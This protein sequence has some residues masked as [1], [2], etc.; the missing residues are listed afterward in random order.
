MALQWCSGISALQSRSAKPSFYCEGL[1]HKIALNRFSCVSLPR[2][3]FSRPI[4]SWRQQ[5]SRGIYYAHLSTSS[6]P[7]I[8]G[9]NGSLVS[10]I[11][12][13]F[14]LHR[15]PSLSTRY[16]LKRMGPRAPKDVRSFY[17]Y[18]PMTK[19]PKWWWR[20]LACLP[21]LKPLPKTWMYAEPAYNLHPFLEDFKFLTFPFL[22]SIERLPGWFLM[23]YFVVAY[24]G[25]VWRKEW[26]HFF[27]FH[28]VLGMLL[29]IAFQVVGTVSRW[30]PLSMYWGKIGMH[31]WTAVAF[32]YLFTVLECIRCMLAGMYADVP[33]CAMQHT[34]RSI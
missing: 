26:P 13:L 10:T 2:V 1:T 20:T 8:C 25:V 7:F 16:R 11:P 6:S 3:V 14:S 30:L 18:L 34:C 29:E 32:G 4:V 12:S 27:R 5:P 9:S 28:V 24:L 33:L 31:F 17:H 23:F 19:K 15:L 22:G 21:Y